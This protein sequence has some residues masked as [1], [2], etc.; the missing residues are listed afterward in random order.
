MSSSWERSVNRRLVAAL[1]AR[2]GEPPP[3]PPA[4]TAEELELEE[5]VARRNRALAAVNPALVEWLGRHERRAERLLEGSAAVRAVNRG[6]RHLEERAARASRPGGFAPEVWKLRELGEWR[7]LDPGDEVRDALE[8]R[9]PQAVLRDLHRPVQLFGDVELRRGPAPTAAASLRRAREARDLA[10]ARPTG[11]AAHMALGSAT[12]KAEMQALAQVL[13]A[14]WA[15]SRPESPLPLPSRAPGGED[16]QW[17]G[18][19]GGYDPD[20]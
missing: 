10:L 5:L 3:P 7:D 14:P 18:M 17:F 20:L 13:G 19:S 2:H 15:D 16:L 9:A 12:M 6:A 1:I 4:P 8:H 11:E